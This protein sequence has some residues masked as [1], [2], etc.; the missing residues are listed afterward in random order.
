MDLASHTKGRRMTP[1]LLSGLALVNINCNKPFD[2]DV[3]VQRFWNSSPVN[4][5]LKVLSFYDP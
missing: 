5:F 4:G 2:Y 3:V 1:E